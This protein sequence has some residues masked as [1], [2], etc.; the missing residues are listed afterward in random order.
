MS[1][2]QFLDVPARRREDHPLNPYLPL[3]RAV[4][5]KYFHS[6]PGDLREYV[7]A[8]Y[9]GLNRAL[10]RYRPDGHTRF[11][12]VAVYYIRLAI[13]EEY[14]ERHAFSSY[15]A[16]RHG[17]TECG[18]SEGTAAFEDEAFQRIEHSRTINRLA[19]LARVSNREAQCIVYSYI[20]ELSLPEIGDLLNI[21]PQAACQYSKRGMKKLQGVFEVCGDRPH[22]DV[23]RV[24]TRKRRVVGGRALL[25]GKTAGAHGAVVFPAV[26]SEP[27][28]RDKPGTRREQTVSSR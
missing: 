4:L 9:L 7:S 27:G 17:L 12:V 26:R 2:L 20:N 22:P 19:R 25:R 15:L 6:V 28:R 11:E 8:G 13:L 16:K 18:L 10:A 3:I 24:C 14:E 1:N 21:S 5:L 23:A